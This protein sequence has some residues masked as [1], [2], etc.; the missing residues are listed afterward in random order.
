MANMEPKP[1]DF[2]RY[3]RKM[4]LPQIGAAGQGRLA[5]S[6]VLLLGC[7]ALGSSIAELLVRA[8]VGFL[9]IVDRDL[10]ELTNLQRQTLFDESD[11][12]GELPK[13]IAAFNRLRKINSAVVIEP[14]V[15]D[16]NAGNIESLAGVDAG[17]TR[18]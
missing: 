17:D 3:Q 10:V 9:R 4:L 11:A 7:G 15:A 2:A 13:A 16:A 5:D 1:G 12:A 8:G 14:V 18:E 6:R